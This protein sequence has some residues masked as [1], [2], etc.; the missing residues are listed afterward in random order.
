[1]KRE[2][3]PML[4]PPTMEEILKI[5]EDIELPKKEAQKFFYH[6]D[7]NGWKVGKVPMKN[8]RSAMQGW[9][10]RYEEKLEQEKPDYRKGM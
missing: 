1:M 9:R 7:A 4:L 5:A 6:Y 10:L 2:R 3:T 8:V